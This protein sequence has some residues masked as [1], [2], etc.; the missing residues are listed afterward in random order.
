MG[1]EALWV[2]TFTPNW[3]EARRVRCRAVRTRRGGSGLR[4]LRDSG[5]PGTIRDRGCSATG[6]VSDLIEATP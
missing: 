6:P 2:V 3:A 5:P 4:A 1:Y